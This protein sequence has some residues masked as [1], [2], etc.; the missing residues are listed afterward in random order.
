[1]LNYFMENF[2]AGHGMAAVMLLLA[3]CVILVI[4]ERD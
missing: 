2:N 3:V 4:F 1:M